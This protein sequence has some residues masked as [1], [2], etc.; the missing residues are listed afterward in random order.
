MSMA[1]GCY[2]RRQFFRRGF[3]GMVAS[4]MAYG[5]QSFARA[6]KA[7]SPALPTN[8][9]P[10]AL[11]TPSI[12]ELDHIA[13]GFGIDD[14][15][16]DDL[17]SFRKNIEGTLASYRRLDQFAEPTLPVKY[18]R[19]PG[20]RPPPAENPLNAWY[21][22][23]SIKG[24]P[25]GRLAGKKIAVK[26]NVCV[27]GIPMMIGSNVMEGFVPDVDATI[28]TRIL[29]AGG[30]IVGKAVCQNLCV[31]GSSDNSDTGPVLNPHDPKRAA[32]GSSSGS[33]ALLVAGECDLSIGADQGGSIR[34]PSSFSGVYGLKPTY[35][36]VPY[37]G[38]FPY[39][40][41]LDHVG[42]MA[43]SAADCALLLEVIAGADGLDPRQ[44]AGLRAGSYTA[45][46]SGHARGLR[47]GVLRE[48]FGSE[49]AEPDVDRMVRNATQRLSQAGASVTEISVPL[50]RDGIHIIAPIVTEGATMLLMTGN[51]MGSNW[52][53]YYASS[54]MGYFAR[55]R[56]IRANDLCET[57][58]HIVVSGQYLH[59]AYQGHYYAKAQNLARV[60]GAAYD[61]AFKAVDVLVM[62]T[63]PMKAP[64]LPGPNV[65]NEQAFPRGI[66]ANTCPF[67]VTGHPALSVPCGMSEGLPVGMMLVGRYWEEATLFRIADAFDHRGRSSALAVRGVPP[68]DH[69]MPTA[70]R[71]AS[72]RNAPEDRRGR[73]FWKCRAISQPADRSR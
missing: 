61:E 19:L 62:P 70:R 53:G 41:T 38:I 52:K 31:G 13:R 22:K 32:G 20:Y 30:E 48:G 12:E 73:S 1:S 21:W 60:L 63:T 43:K 18:P 69:R 16:K 35:G 8:T 54:L 46:L 72:L 34:I 66:A 2:S 3:T 26:D 51:G 10:K 40:M 47:I 27:A 11:R 24:E 9:A 33:A 71:R 67:D 55:S 15:T 17:G 29:E 50:H 58:K 59:E 23:C 14:L 25:S 64:L 36:L 65:S 37:T 5:G 44:P 49:G 28:V 57:F 39:E 6:L 68:P 45:Q 42:P 56:R 4:S 7:D